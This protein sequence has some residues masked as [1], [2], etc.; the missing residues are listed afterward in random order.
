MRGKNS[1]F[2]FPSTALTFLSVPQRIQGYTRFKCNVWL[3]STNKICAVKCWAA[4]ENLLR[5]RLSRDEADASEH[6][7][8]IPHMRTRGLQCD[9]LNWGGGLRLH[10]AGTYNAVLK[11]L[12]R[13]FNHHFQLDSCDQCGVTTQLMAGW[14]RG[15]GGRQCIH[16]WE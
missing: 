16:G 13:W 12:H 14:G 1:Q 10:L 11:S 6:T 4:A 9:T 3:V 7:W 8:N 2:D 5:L 15:E